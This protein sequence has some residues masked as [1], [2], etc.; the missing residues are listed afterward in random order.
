MTLRTSFGVTKPSPEAPSNKPA[1]ISPST[2][3]IPNRLKSSPNIL[4]VIRI[5]KKIKKKRKK[6]RRKKEIKKKKRKKKK[7]KKKK[8]KIKKKKKK[9]GEKKKKKKKKV[10]I[11]KGKI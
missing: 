4:A 10:K 11:Q 6:I 7:R 9:R 5:R 3:G 8:K 1:E 2:E